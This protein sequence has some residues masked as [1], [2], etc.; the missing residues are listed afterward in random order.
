[1]NRGEGCGAVAVTEMQLKGVLL[2]YSLNQ[3]SVLSQRS[4][5]KGKRDLMI[6]L[7]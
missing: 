3:Q 7:K 5:R 4:E 6:Y 2:N 1:M